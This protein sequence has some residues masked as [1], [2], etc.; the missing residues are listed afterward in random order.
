[1]P[2]FLHVGCGPKRKNQTVKAFAD[3]AWEEVTLDI[4]EN[5]RPDIVDKL[6][7]M[8]H[9]A[10]DSFDAVYSAHNIEHLYPHEV[11]LAL[12]AMQRVLKQD[13]FVILTC[14]DLQ[15]IGERL[16]QGDIETPLYESGRGPVSPIDMLFGFRPAMESGNLY[17][18]HHTGFT[19]KSLRDACIRSGFAKFFGFRRP[20]RHDLWGLATKSQKTD[21]EVRELGK[22]YLNPV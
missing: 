13:G 14:P 21:E 2:R 1:M 8:S 18:A 16:S 4:D 11:S 12:Q 6:P 17:M 15:T 19:L 10:S 9:V 5:V 22:I 7:E 20:S 3:R